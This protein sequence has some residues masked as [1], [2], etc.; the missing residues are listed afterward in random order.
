MPRLR[1][2]LPGLLGQP[3]ESGLGTALRE[4]A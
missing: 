3:D 1:G 4:G 2:K